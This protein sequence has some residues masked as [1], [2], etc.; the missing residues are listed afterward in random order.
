MAIESG[1]SQTVFCSTGPDWEA[2]VVCTLIGEYTASCS[3]PSDW[4]LKVFASASNMVSLNWEAGMVHTL[5][6]ECPSSLL[7]TG[8]V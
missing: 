8:G 2:G 1:V 5:G 6:G 4:P 7:T 3:L